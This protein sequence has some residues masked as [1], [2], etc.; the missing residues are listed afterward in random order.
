[1]YYYTCKPSILNESCIWVF[2]G[3]VMMQQIG[4]SSSIDDGG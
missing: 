1:L 3:V 2:G 4:S